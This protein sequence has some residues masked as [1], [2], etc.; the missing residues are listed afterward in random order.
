MIEIIHELNFYNIAHFYTFLL[1][2][3]KLKSPKN[4]F[5]AVLVDVI[6][7]R[8]FMLRGKNPVSW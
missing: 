3:Q 2:T 7:N 6:G 4:E 1:C 5:E 8:M